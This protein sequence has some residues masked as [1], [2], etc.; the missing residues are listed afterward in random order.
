MS[1]RSVLTTAIK[2]FGLY[3]LVLAAIDFRNTIVSILF[4]AG[5]DHPIGDRWGP[6]FL[7]TLAVILNVVVGFILLNKA[8][9]IAKRVNAS[10]SH[11]V[12]LPV[13]KTDIVE[14]ALIVV[15]FIAAL[16]AIPLILQKLVTYAY[17]NP[18]EL[19]ERKH[20]WTIHDTAAIIYSLFEFVAGL[21]LILNARSF[22][23]KL[24]RVSDREDARV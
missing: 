22:A 3:F 19:S 5:S 20:F 7:S 23:R 10:S 2:I 18:Y 15:G 9:D 1:T 6:I 16:Y 11:S 14:L 24:Q 17:F 8:D 21:F 4:Q 13:T 12:N